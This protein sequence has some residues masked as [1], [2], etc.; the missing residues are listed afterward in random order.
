MTADSRSKRVFFALLPDRETV[1]AINFHANQFSPDTGSKVRAENFHITLLFLGNVSTQS[2][3][4][5]CMDCDSLA[6]PAFDL[7]INSP[8]WWKKAGILWLGPNDIPAALDNLHQSLRS[9]ATRHRIAT[10]NK[11]YVPHITLLRK[12]WEAPENPVVRPFTWSADSFT[13]MQ[14]ETLPDGARYTELASWSLI[15]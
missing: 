14:S 11:P 12:V 6:N 1:E 15:Q 8:G 13:L 7:I 4:N 5:L 9:L 10:D 2:I 3:E